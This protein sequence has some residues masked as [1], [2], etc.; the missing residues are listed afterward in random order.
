MISRNRHVW[1]LLFV[2]FLVQAVLFYQH[3]VVTT[4]EAEKYIR[5]GEFLADTGKLTENR[6]MFYIPVIALIALCKM[7]HLSFVFV[8]IIQVLVAAIALYSFYQVAVHL[9]SRKWALAVSLL[10]ACCI[11]VQEW[12]MYLYSDSL[13]ISLSII[14][15]SLF[16]FCSVNN[17]FTLEVM[18]FLPVVWC[19]A[20]PAGLLFML[21]VFIL[22][23]AAK[24][25]RKI[26]LFGLLAA[27]L[28]IILFAN[29]YFNG[30]GDLDTLKPYIEEHIICFVPQNPAGAKLDIVHTGNQLN[31]LFYYVLHNPGHFFSLLFQKLVSF[32]NLTRP[33]Y[34]AAHNAALVALMIP[35]Y[36]F[37]IPGIVH[38][39]RNRRPFAWFVLSVLIIYPVGVAMQCDDWH[40]RFT[41]PVLPL[42]ILVAFYGMY[43]LISFRKR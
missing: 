1:L 21:P 26:Y 37:F 40:S 5:E 25:R 33:W 35:M 23:F 41:M 11:P 17:R 29:T 3:G 20:R 34:S 22:F 43:S 15:F 10:L 31:D 12:N 14:F 42:I 28:A 19:I 24:A 9:S 27:V 13:F 39:F 4:L 8:V 32:F 30:G 7:L 18:A 36:L 16:Y 6:F 38:L 2:F